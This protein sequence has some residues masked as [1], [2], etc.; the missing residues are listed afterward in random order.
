MLSKQIF[1]Q[2]AIAPKA[3][4]PEFAAGDRSCLFAGS[5]SFRMIAT[6]YL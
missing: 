3:P 1:L 6:I 4:T 2:K 5:R